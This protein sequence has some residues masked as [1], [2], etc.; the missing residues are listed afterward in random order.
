MSPCY[1]LKNNFG[2]ARVVIKKT[3]K[4]PQRELE[5]ARQRAKEVK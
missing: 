4:T 3:Q 2:A 5:L 1:F